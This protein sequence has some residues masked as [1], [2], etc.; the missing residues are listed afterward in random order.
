M[1]FYVYYYTITM[2]LSYSTVPT[3]PVSV[4]VNAIAGQPNQLLVTWQLP[5]V[6]NGVVTEYRVFCFESMRAQDSTDGSGEDYDVTPMSISFQNSVSN[7]TLLG[8]ESSAVMGGLDP[9]TR[10]DCTAVAY[11][12]A[13]EGEASTFVSAVTD[14]SSK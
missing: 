14:Q 3:A 12:S 2:L 8:N 6:P 7:A 4:G 13:G 1:F 10:Y 5:D 11:T 9:Y